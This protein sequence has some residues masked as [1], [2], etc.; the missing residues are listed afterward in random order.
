MINEFIRLI[1]GTTIG[2]LAT[3]LNFKQTTVVEVVNNHLAIANGV[4]GLIIGGFTL[5]FLFL[6]IKKIRRDLKNKK[7]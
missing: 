5:V 4:I 6:Q 3:I 1:S 2:T 7:S